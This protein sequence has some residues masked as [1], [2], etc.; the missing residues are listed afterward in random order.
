MTVTADDLEAL[1]E[2]YKTWSASKGEH[3]APWLGLMA[4]DF[5]NGTLENG[6]PGLEFSKH[7]RGKAA[8]VE[9][10]RLLHRDWRMVCHVAEEFLQDRDR[11]V[12][13]IRTTW[14]HRDT[15][16]T[17]DSPAAHVWRF[18]NGKAI[19][20]FE[21]VDSAAWKEAA[22]PDPNIP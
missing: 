15:G 16:K 4:E 19:S 14:Q 13:L 10:F 11:I 6:A 7:R 22:R 1:K 9:Y 17:V 3:Y 20:K 2:A 21:F 8:M 5:E 18:Q 12:V